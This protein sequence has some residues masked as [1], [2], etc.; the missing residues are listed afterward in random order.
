MFKEINAESVKTIDIRSSTRR[1]FMLLK[2]EYKSNNSDLNDILKE[3]SKELR[4][5]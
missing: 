3:H 2:N 4:E 5:R 1:W